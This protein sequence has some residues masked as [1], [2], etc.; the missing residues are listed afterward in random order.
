MLTKTINMNSGKTI[1]FIGSLLVI[2]VAIMIFFMLMSTEMPPSNRE[3]LIA[4]VSVMF[5]SMASSIKKITGDDES[6]IV[7]ELQN[8]NKHLKQRIEDLTKI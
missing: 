5:G 1:N 7:K 4:F 2:S 3:L 8:E 6:E